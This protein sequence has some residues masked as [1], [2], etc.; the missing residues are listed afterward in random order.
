MTDKGQAE[1]PSRQMS[2][3]ELVLFEQAGGDISF[4]IYQP[5]R[6]YS[7]RFL[8]VTNLGVPGIFKIDWDALAK[9]AHK[10]V[11]GDNK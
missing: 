10:E 7:N 8:H 1:L 11:K 9:L 6:D 5:D 4:K 3:I 2:L